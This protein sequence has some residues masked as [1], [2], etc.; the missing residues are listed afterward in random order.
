MKRF[1]TSVFL[2]VLTA[3]ICSAQTDQ[4]GVHEAIED[5]LEGLYQVA[6]ERIERS[7]SKSLVKF[8]YWRDSPEKEYVGYPMSYDQLMRLAA[9]WNVGNK[10]KLDDS[11]PREI[12]V[13]DVL[14]KTAVAKLTAHWG[15]DYF[16]LEKVEGKW[17]IRHII[18]QGHP[19]K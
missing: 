13:L 1:L 3:G 15:I 2:F 16:Q 9:S 12:A 4:Q 19:G 17:M 14:N 18:W 6:P 11:T 7:V 10:M 5:Y 8:G